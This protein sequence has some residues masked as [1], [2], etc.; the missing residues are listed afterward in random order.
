MLDEVIAALRDRCPTFAKRVAGAAE[1]NALSENAKLAVPAAYVLPLDDKP[2]DAN[3]NAGFRQTLRDSFGVVVA[4]D[5]QADQR[6]QK[7]TSDAVRVIRPELFRALLGWDP[8]DDH[9]PI[10]YEGGQLQDM[11]RSVL[12]Y[13]FEFGADTVIEQADTY[14]GKVID[15]APAL[16]TVTIT[17]DVIDHQDAD[18]GPVNV[19]GTPVPGAT[20]TIPQT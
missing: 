20:I 8:D 16:E 10:T 18:L 14:A 1:F 19:A 17:L 4:L 7:A 6:G 3:T 12:W 5:N 11:N 15:D 13:R 9:G 2:G